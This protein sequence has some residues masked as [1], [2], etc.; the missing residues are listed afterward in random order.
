MAKVRSSS[1]ER[2][3]NIKRWLGVNEA[4]EGEASLK[5]GEA[6]ASRNFRVTS[7]GALQ[8]RPGSKNVAGLLLDYDLTA[9]QSERTLFT[10]YGRM[11]SPLPMFPSAAVDSVGH[12]ACSGEPTDVSPENADASVGRFYPFEGGVYRLARCV[13]SAASGNERVDGGA[14]RL[15]SLQRFASGRTD[16]LSG[17]QSNS[18]T[19]SV[20]TRPVLSCVDGSFALSGAESL[21]ERAGGNAPGFVSSNVGGFLQIG[22]RFWKYYGAKVE[23][24]SSGKR[25]NKF[26]CV[27]S[28]YTSYYSYYAQGGW[29]QSYTEQLSE[30][31]TSLGYTGYYF[32][33]SSGRF[34]TSGSY[35]EV[36]YGKPGTV[37]YLNSGDGSSI[38]RITASGNSA[39]YFECSAQGPYTGSSVSTSYSKGSAEGTV[40]VMD[41]Q[42]PESASMSY[43]TSFSEGGISYTVM[44]DSS[45]NY[46]CYCPAG[47]SASYFVREYG[48]Y[49]Y[50]LE[51]AP[52]AYQ[53]R[54]FDMTVVPNSST[55]TQV[56]GLWAGF[57]GQSE[58]LCAACNGHLW[59]LSHA[60]GGWSK[61]SCGTLDTSGTVFMFGFD[62]KL[63]ILN[64]SEY[65]VWDGSVLQNVEGY[66]P[67]V[68]V[69]SPPSGGGTVLERVNLLTPGRRAR[70]SPDGTSKTFQLPETALSSVDSATDLATGRTVSGFTVNLQKGVV[71]FNSA[72][73]AGVDSLEIAYSVGGSL[74]SRVT[75]MR[76][77]E[78]YNGAQDTRV[79]LYGDGSNKTVY[80]GIDHDG[81]ARA[82]YFPD[83]NE[84][85]VGDGNTPITAM[86]RHY[87]RLLCFK[88][89]SAWCLYYDAITLTDGTVTAGF[90]VSPVNRDVGNCAPG[91]VCLVENRPRTLDGRSVIEWRVAGSS[92]NP[93]GDQRN[94]ERI[95]QRVEKTIRSFDLTAARTFYDKIT[96]EYYVIGSGGE[97]LVHNVEADAWY[98]YTGFPAACMINYKDEV[99]YGTNDGYLRHFST[100]Y[101]SDEGAPIDACWESG[102]MD[103]GADF[104]RKYSAMLW[105]GIRPEEAGFL[106][107]TAQ[108]DRE[109]NLAA[110]SFGTADASALP[111][112]ELVRLKAKK[113]TYYKLILRSDRINTAATVVSADLRVR[114]AG[115]V[116]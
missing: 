4:Q 42:R 16:N 36:G 111:A 18:G 60:D 24:F 58:V 9:S 80:S 97:A 74:R 77:A 95:S 32:S 3:Y 109:N 34:Y 64:G 14:I 107:V 22:N 79:F 59:E 86:I 85:A 63:Y 28:D 116:R 55:D 19:Q 94:A 30:G 10:S 72:P 83:L 6:A 115:Y 65:L 50:P 46:W 45:G 113:F 61:R 7:G 98:V 71:T 66:R 25:W 13:K 41:G 2:V 103:F 96:H 31:T 99:Y 105:I 76:F 1:Q 78:L 110:Y 81:I 33:S 93:A 75:G 108:T 73:A 26:R 5:F 15:G 27:R 37:Y 12:V 104:R 48:W 47:D 114:G 62:E 106:A 70:F 89:D 29:S 67:L 100:D 11:S 38:T 51:T 69:A 102:A 91:Q 90:Y 40:L 49:G 53:W 8:K 54:F 20:S 23:S 92:G 17:S 84:A 44:R 43:V 87:N 57:V 88:L 112:M 101:L 52:D 35:T 21:R 56:R 39:T 68:T 82:D